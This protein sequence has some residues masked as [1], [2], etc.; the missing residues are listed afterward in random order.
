VQQAE[1]HNESTAD[2]ALQVQCYNLH[3]EP[4]V[5]VV[6]NTTNDDD[7]ADTATVN[8][9]NDEGVEESKASEPNDSAPHGTAVN[10]IV[11]KPSIE[12]CL[13]QWQKH[14]QG[15]LFLFRIQLT[16]SQEVYGALSYLP[17]QDGIE[18]K[19]LLTEWNPHSR[20]M[21]FFEGR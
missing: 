10:S 13:D 1:L 6:Q 14:R 21:C 16:Q 19:D 8:A 5:T 3:E 20:L 4:P 9:S 18:S 17:L 15:E 7:T 2:M 11:N 12:C